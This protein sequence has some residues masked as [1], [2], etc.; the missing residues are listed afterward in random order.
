MANFLAGTYILISRPVRIGDFVR[1]ENGEEGY[2]ISIGWRETRIRTLPNNVVVVPNQKLAQMVV[3]NYYIPDK[4]MACL[5]QV[6][7][8][9][10]SDLEKVEKTTVE[11]GKEVLQRVSGGVKTFE[12]FIRYHTF[13]DFSINFTVILR[14]AEFVDKYLVTHEFIKALHKRY[15]KEGIEIP[16]PIRTVHLRQTDCE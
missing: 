3:T 11:V 4:E 2:V 1:L 16:F 13:S 9:Y 5:V 15:K 7:V 12:P 8:S 14:V 10:D 6:G